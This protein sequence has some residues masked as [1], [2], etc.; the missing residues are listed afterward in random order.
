MVSP[1]VRCV[2]QHRGRR[3][4]VR[5]GS[6]FACVCVCACVYD[7]NPRHRVTAISLF[8]AAVLCMRVRVC[9]CV[10]CICV[11]FVVA[12]HLGTAISEI[13]AALLC[14]CTWAIVSF[15]SC[16]C[17]SSASGC[18]F[19]IISAARL[20]VYV[21]MRVCAF[22]CLRV[23]ASVCVRWYVCIWQ[24][25]VIGIPLSYHFNPRAWVRVR[26]CGCA[27]V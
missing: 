6:V 9:G 25:L 4:V 23:Y 1:N 17:S 19:S 21:R 14:G 15:C 3:T 24:P 20:C 12:R 18:R 5:F 11:L 16:C 22:A 7:S 13:S 8:S 10:M 2:T 26:A 27:C